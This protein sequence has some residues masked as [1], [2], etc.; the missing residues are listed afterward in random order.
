MQQLELQALPE[1]CV[2]KVISL[3]TPPDAC[4]LSLLCKVIRLAAESDAVWN[5]FLPPE[6]NEILSH[7]ESASAVKSKK[8]LYMSLSN[9]PILI[10][11]GNMVI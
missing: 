7:S 3:T 4:R 10:N 11:D 5:N 8:D 9:N 6:I 2:A 1:G